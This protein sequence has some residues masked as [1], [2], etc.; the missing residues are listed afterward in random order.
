MA[1]EYHERAL[2][3][4]LKL[5]GEEH[6]D[7]AWSLN[8][9]GVDY[10]GLKDY[11][12]AKECDERALAI[13]LK[14]HGEEHADTA[15]SLNNLGVDYINLGDYAKAKEYHERALAIRLKLYGEEHADTALS[16]HN[17][18]YDYRGLKDH[19][20][21]KECD[22]RALAIRLKLHGEEHADTASSLNGLGI[23]YTGLGDHAK[24]LECDERALAIRLK[25]YGEEHAD[26]ASSLRD[27]GVDYSGLE[28][29]AKAKE[30]DERALA[31]RLKLYGEEHA[32]TAG[33]LNNLGYDY[34]GLKD[35]TKA[36]QCDERALAIR[37]KLYGEDHADTLDSLYSLLIINNS[38][39]NYKEAARLGERLLAV[40]RKNS[41]E[42]SLRTARVLMEIWET[43]QGT[44]DY[45]GALKAL[46]EA[47]DIHTGL[48]E[49]E[50]NYVFFTLNRL[51][52][53]YSHLGAAET[54][55]KET[56]PLRERLVA[57]LENR[58]RN[59]TLRELHHLA[60][61]YDD[62][63]E[64]E[65][66]IE[67][68]EKELA[69][70]EKTSMSWQSPAHCAAAVYF[71]LENYV[72]AKEYRRQV[73]DNFERAYGWEN[74]VTAHAAYMLAA[75]CE[76]LKEYE[77]A[78][79]L[80]ERALTVFM[81]TD[82][83]HFVRIS[84]ATLSVICKRMGLNN[85]GIFYGKMAIDL[86]QEARVNLSSLDEDV[87]HSY[88]RDKEYLYQEVADL[89]TEQGRIAEAQQVLAM[90]KEEEYFDFIRRDQE[91]DPRNSVVSYT[92]I[93]KKMADQ[94]REISAR[95]FALAQEKEELRKKKPTDDTEWESSADAKRL[96]E[97]D[98]DL[99]I[100][101]KVFQSFLV[102]LD[103][104]MKTVSDANRKKEID[105]MNLD[106][107]Q[108]LK[109]TLKDMKHGAALIHTVITEERLWLILTTS[110]LQLA[111]ESRIPQ[112]ELYKKILSFRESL[113]DPRTDPLPMAREFYDLL[114]GPMAKDLEKS[115]AQTLMFSLD[116]QLRYIPMSALHDGER[117]LAEKYAIAL[118]TEAAKDKLKDKRDDVAWKAAAMGVTRAHPGFNRLPAVRDELESIV[119]TA[120]NGA[121][122]LAG[123]PGTIRLDEKF[124]ESAFAEALEEGV[125]VVHVASHFRFEPGTVTD[126]FLLLGDGKH[127]TL[128]SIN[129]GVFAFE[130]VEQ[131]TFSACDTA[132]GT[133]EGAGREV[134]GLGV[135]AQKRG[136][137]SVMATLWSVA[138]ASTGI[139]MSRYYSLLQQD[140]MTKAEALRLAQTEFIKSTAK[141]VV[142]GKNEKSGTVKGAGDEPLVS[143]PG[144][145]HPYFWAPF[146]L[147]G[148][149]L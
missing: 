97:I 2:A 39:M 20:K 74:P 55:L 12:K 107:L 51:V 111:Y 77:Q 122:N 115:G 1:K 113:K 135:V 47:Y 16:L 131:L 9:L 58:G 81:K 118:Y 50:E 143:F 68:F 15:W 112:A 128:E 66:A 82:D 28:D 43:Y 146:I 102:A 14:L 130:N 149:W 110:E 29:Y 52:V 45:A 18:G 63:G 56:K 141:P 44:G 76:S 21:A 91:N 124:T 57:T 22:E 127:L 84:L 119:R 6:A 69:V 106:A 3:I 136:T 126:S 120:D 99:T 123:L 27:L 35:Y 142:A 37:L 100:A 108:G 144:Y 72:K 60:H 64:P 101:N 114:V 75:T 133:E 41:G 83:K 129:V 104:E 148:N 40:E 88:L 80:Y 86:T 34:R 105:K 145:S 92:G 46:K 137:K 30:C 132:M 94:F 89:L 96:A 19:A 7:T 61:L 25:L 78:K 70:Y 95:L 59:I 48:P 139:F 65:K 117:W 90:M 36:K 42:K 38:L 31:I 26:T 24:A 17:L 109:K 73:L 33:S 49:L 79:E 32:D 103:E 121:E 134:E 67:C 53:L 11:A 54:G 125:P 116:G 71:E 147:M 62:L 85:A 98:G 93:E 140:G 23:D 4:Y 10:S 138:D 8:N 87:Q 5:Y 13:Y